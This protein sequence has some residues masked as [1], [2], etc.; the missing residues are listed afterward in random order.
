VAIR[1]SKIVGSGITEE[2]VETIELD[3]SNPDDG[4][5]MKEW[6]E[7]I[8]AGLNQPWGSHASIIAA[9]RLRFQEIKI[10]LKEVERGSKEYA[11]HFK[12]RDSEPWYVRE[13]VKT[14]RAVELALEGGRPW[15]AVSRAMQIGELLAE[16]RLKRWD[17]PALF[18]EKRLTEMREQ[19][20]KSRR[21]S[22]QGRIDRVEQLVQEGMKVTYAIRRVA[23]EH[24][25]SEA[26]IKKDLY[27]R[28][29]PSTR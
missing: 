13:I 24:E 20:R 15:E 16:F 22:K 23:R 14:A 12:E 26:A 28:R 27:P 8:S 19:G 9:T 29:K 11:A 10:E 25:V 18:G 1:R 4:Q 21:S 5:L 3:P 7:G 2:S 6:L 17:K